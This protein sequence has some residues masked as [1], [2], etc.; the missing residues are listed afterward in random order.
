MLGLLKVIV[1]VAV[2]AVVGGLATHWVKDK[3]TSEFHHAIDTSLPS[4]A[5]RR[6][7]GRLSATASPSARPGCGST[8]AG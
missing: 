8:T 5:R 2:I 3:A 4:R 6:T 7:P 1:V